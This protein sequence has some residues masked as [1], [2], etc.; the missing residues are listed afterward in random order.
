[1]LSIRRASEQDLA[2]W[3]DFVYSS[4]LGTI[5]HSRGWIE[6]HKKSLG[7][8]VIQLVARDEGRMVGVFPFRVIP[9][10][11]D[12]AIRYRDFLTLRQV[13]STLGHMETPYGGPVCDPERPDV[14]R[15]L[16]KASMGVAG[17]FGSLRVRFS[18]ALAQNFNTGVLTFPGSSLQTLETIL[19]DLGTSPE[20]IR[21]NFSR[22]ARRSI[23]KAEEAGVKV[24][25]ATGNTA[26]GPYH[27]I[28]AETYQRSGFSPYRQEFYKSVFD[29][30]FPT[31]QARLL[32]A[33][34]DGKPV[35]GAFVLMDR[36]TVYNW[37]G[38]L[39]REYVRTQSYS[40]LQRD[41]IE[42]ARIEGFST[43]DLCGIDADHPGIAAFKGNFGGRVCRFPTMG[44][45]G[46]LQ[47]FFK[48]LRGEFRSLVWRL[49][50]GPGRVT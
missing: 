45:N 5:F 20:T 44:V 39:L 49:R 33:I 4:P 23:K 48:D 8:A 38:G 40:L 41:H 26:I 50:G 16:L 25:E 9:V 14:L 3:D 11:I 19:V 46:Q 18:P 28:L 21:S 34:Y 35:A 24:F 42:R 12:E 1:V 7:T 36:K 30:F 47:G 27:R 37:T 31:K 17:Q 22:R 43:Y 2:G 13:F 6:A 15:S 32:F 29:T 10:P